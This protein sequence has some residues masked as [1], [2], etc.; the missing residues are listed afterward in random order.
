[1]TTGYTSNCSTFLQELLT[2]KTLQKQVHHYG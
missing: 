1:M 2:M